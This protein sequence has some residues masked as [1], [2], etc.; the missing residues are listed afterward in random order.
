[1]PLAAERVNSEVA[2]IGAGVAGLSAARYLHDNGIPV[3]V[4]DKARRPGGRLATSQFHD[5]QFDHGAQY[6]R[7]HS[8]RTAVLF[9]KWRKA[10]LIKVWP[11]LAYELPQRK[12][13]DTTSWHVATPSQNALASHLAD[14][15]NVCCKFTALAISGE[16]GCW[17]VI[18]QKSQSAGPFAAVFVACPSA[19]AVELLGPFPAL[20]DV[21]K[22]SE[23]RPCLTTMVE[24]EEEVMTDYDAAFISHGPL[25]WVCRDSAKPDRPK[26]ECWVLQATEEWSR[27]NLEEPPERIA[28]LM[29]SAFAPLSAVE[30]PPVSFCRSHR[31]RH[32]YGSSPTKTTHMFRSEIGLGIAGDWCNTANVDG[33]YWSGF[34]L[35]EAYVQSLKTSKSAR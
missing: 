8:R 29:L 7:P 32:A 23:S 18:G 20:Y 33:A 4:F 34:D 28:S 16:K 26:N 12:K 9:S 31:W 25:A 3:V 15:L 24:F 22:M 17:S 21:A 13:V 11:A 2:I 19:E 14:G 10:G 30:L 6:L 35:A 27:T 5:R 1:V